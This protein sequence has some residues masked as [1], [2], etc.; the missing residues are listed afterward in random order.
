MADPGKEATKKAEPIETLEQEL[1]DLSA[2]GNT[3]DNSCFITESV[4]FGPCGDYEE[5]TIN[6]NNLPNQARLLN[7]KLVIKDVCRGREIALGVILFDEETNKVLGFKGKTVTLP[8]TGCGK[9]IIDG[10]CF[11]IPERTICDSRNVG[12]RV[13]GHYTKLNTNPNCPC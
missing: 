1:I 13:T 10:F 12:V 8:G 3:V 6:I 9:L 5:K 4:C 7:I 11:V 2:P